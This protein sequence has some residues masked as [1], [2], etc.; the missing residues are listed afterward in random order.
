MLIQDPETGE[1]DFD[2]PVRTED[3]DEESELRKTWDA[4]FSPERV[5]VISPWSFSYP[6]RLR[7][8]DK[9]DG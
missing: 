3:P 2:W 8:K 6:T 5:N 9:N 7:R 1:W 4:L